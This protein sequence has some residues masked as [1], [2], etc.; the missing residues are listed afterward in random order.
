MGEVF[1]ET[2]RKK[3]NAEEASKITA[4]HVALVLTGAWA[5]PNDEFLT[6]VNELAAEVNKEE[7]KMEF[8]YVSCDRT[9]E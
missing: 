9:K 3:D 7:L 6:K 4:P 1:G 5:K 8:V 2:L